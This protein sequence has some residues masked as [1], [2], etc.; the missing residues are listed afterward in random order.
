[1][2]ARW[3]QKATSQWHPRHWDAIRARA[4][5]HRP[6]AT[7]PLLPLPRT[8]WETGCAVLAGGFLRE[9][10]KEPALAAKLQSE[11]QRLRKACRCHS[12]LYCFN[13]VGNAPEFDNFVV[14]VRDSE[15]CTRVPVA[16]L[17]DGTRIQQVGGAGF[18][19]EK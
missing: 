4:G 18:D 14:D 8:R 15:G 11:D 16:R 7:E 19:P 17:A 6:A 13:I 9:T 5:S 3:D 10:S 1:M 12:L 2:F